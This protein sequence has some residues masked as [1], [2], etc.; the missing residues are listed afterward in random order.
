MGE[1]TESIL[2]GDMYGYGWSADYYLSVNSSN[3]QPTVLG[4]FRAQYPL[5]PA[6]SFRV[7]LLVPEPSALAL[8]GVG[9]MGLLAYVWRRRTV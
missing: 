8:I 6:E 7:V 9:A 4:D 3:P 2:Y 5:T 1:W